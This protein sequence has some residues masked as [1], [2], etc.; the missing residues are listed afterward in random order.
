MP[1]YFIPDEHQEGDVH[2]AWREVEAADDQ[3][4]LAQIKPEL[5]R[6]GD[7]IELIRPDA[8][9]HRVHVY[10]IVA[11]GPEGRWSLRRWR[12]RDM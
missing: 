12:T 10:H 11:V 4:A 2:N 3:A 8:Q 9:G 6:E 7:R 5:L 1:T